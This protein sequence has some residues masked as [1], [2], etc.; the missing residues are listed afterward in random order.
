MK[1]IILGCSLWQLGHKLY[2]SGEKIQV[3]TLVLFHLNKATFL[4]H[5]Y[6]RAGRTEFP[7]LTIFHTG[8]LKYWQDFLPAMSSDKRT[9]TLLSFHKSVP[10]KGWSKLSYG[11]L[12]FT[13]P[14]MLKSNWIKIIHFHLL[15]SCKRCLMFISPVMPLE[16]ALGGGVICSTFPHP[17][18]QQGKFS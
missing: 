2:F 9:G 11:K 5:I 8:N 12:E 10:R 1:N 15:F 18:H 3:S 4:V 16:R 17:H 13:Q 7:F 14:W 6:N